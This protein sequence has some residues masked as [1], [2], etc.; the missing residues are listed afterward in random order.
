M[1][2]VLLMGILCILYLVLLLSPYRCLYAF[3]SLAV[4]TGIVYSLEGAP[5]LLLYSGVGILCIVHDRF[6]AI[7]V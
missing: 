4:H 2:E 1:H 5:Y 7:S 6:I 3:L